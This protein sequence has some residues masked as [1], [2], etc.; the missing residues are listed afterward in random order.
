MQIIP[1]VG[2]FGVILHTYKLIRQNGKQTLFEDKGN[3][4]YFCI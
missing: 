2:K 4:K 1:R 3:A